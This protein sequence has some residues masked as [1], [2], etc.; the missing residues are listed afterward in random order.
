MVQAWKADKKRSDMNAGRERLGMGIFMALYAQFAK[1]HPGD[2]YIDQHFLSVSID[3]YAKFVRTLQ[4]DSYTTYS[5]PHRN[6]KVRIYNYPWVAHFYCE[7]FKLTQEKRYLTD[8][9]RTQM[10]QFRDGGMNFYAIDM[11]AMRAT[12]SVPRTVSWATC[13]CSTAKVSAVAPTNIP[14]T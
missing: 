3:L 7:M 6:D 9:Y 8:A 10:A 12:A 11:P 13:C 5:S 14:T 1:K 4:S 2:C